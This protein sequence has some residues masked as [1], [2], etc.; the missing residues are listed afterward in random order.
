M[1][2]ARKP[3]GFVLVCFLA[4]PVADAGSQARAGLITLQSSTH[5]AVVLSWSLPFEATGLG[6][7]EEEGV[8]AEPADAG[9]SLA[10]PSRQPTPPGGAGDPKPCVLP[11]SPGAQAAGG[12]LP[13][14]GP[15]SVHHLG[16]ACPAL[17]AGSALSCPSPVG[18]LAIRRTVVRPRLLASGVFHPPRPPWC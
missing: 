5:P 3:F 7:F 16:T 15:S 12:L 11:P 17:A 8:A 2:R 10:A 6:L 4:W 13:P 1:G 9:E 18:W 14:S